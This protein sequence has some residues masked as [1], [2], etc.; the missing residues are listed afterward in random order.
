[1]VA[2][3]SFVPAVVAGLLHQLSWI[4][5]FNGWVR[6]PHHWSVFTLPQR[7]LFGNSQQ[8]IIDATR[9]LLTPRWRFLPVASPPVMGTPAPR[10]ILSEIRTHTGSTP[11]LAVIVDPQNKISVNS[12]R[13]ERLAVRPPPTSDAVQGDVQ[14]T[15]ASIRHWRHQA[16]HPPDTPDKV[17]QGPMMG[18]TL[19]IATVRTGPE[20]PTPLDQLLQAQGW[21]SLFSETLGSS[22]DPATVTVWAEPQQTRWR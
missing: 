10:R 5:L 6:V 4:P 15:T 13:T 21:K 2:F 16:R 18:R 11:F 22:F 8:G 19:Y 17:L 1:M 3:D 14:A 20:G 12:L 9:D 7:D